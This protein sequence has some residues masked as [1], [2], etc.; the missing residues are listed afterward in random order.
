MKKTSK[1]LFNIG[2]LWFV[3]TV[4]ALMTSIGYEYLESIGFLF[5]IE[6]AGWNSRKVALG[7]LTFVA[8]GLVVVKTFMMVKDATI[9]AKTEQPP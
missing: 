2:L 3:W 9:P 7:V 6:G 8:F 4:F 5:E 1:L